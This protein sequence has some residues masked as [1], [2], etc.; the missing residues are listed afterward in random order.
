MQNLFG[1]QR[2][3]EAR[4]LLRGSALSILEAAASTDDEVNEDDSIAS[5]RE[6]VKDN[7]HDD[8]ESHSGIVKGNTDIDFSDQ[9]QHVLKPTPII[10]PGQTLCLDPG[11]SLQNRTILRLG[12]R[13]VDHFWQS[14]DVP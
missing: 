4:S 12:D 7:S 10:R 5:P 6:E 3:E 11:S 14:R 8:E 9:S 2:A 13:G 1:F